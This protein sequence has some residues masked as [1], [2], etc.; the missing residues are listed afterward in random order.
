VTTALSA[1]MS[2][3]N[4]D[5]DLPI[6]P[7]AIPE[8]PYREK[9]LFK[10]MEEPTF[11]EFDSKKCGNLTSI[12][13]N[14]RWPVSEISCKKYFILQSNIILVYYIAHTCP[15]LKRLD[16]EFCDYIG[17]NS[18]KKLFKSCKNLRSLKITS[19]FNSLPRSIFEVISRN[20]TKLRELT[21]K[22]FHYFE[23]H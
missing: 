18:L 7:Y 16:L 14:Y 6:M 20:G 8:N 11:N 19:M 9:P 17:P 12:I 2:T 13:V 22:Y 10:E 3:R 15:N 23:T 1:D 21:I 4:P 5:K